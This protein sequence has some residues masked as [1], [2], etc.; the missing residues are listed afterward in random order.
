MPVIREVHFFPDIVLIGEPD[1][2]RAKPNYYRPPPPPPAATEDEWGGD[3][4]YGGGFPVAH[5]LEHVVQ[6]RLAEAERTFS[7]AQQQADDLLSEA[8]QQAAEMTSR[9][10]DDL[11]AARQ[12][13]EQLRAAAEDQSQRIR[14]QAEAAGHLSGYDAGR[15]DG[16]VKV[17]AEM[18]EKIAHVT[19]L[20]VSAAVDRRELLHNAE[21]E[22]VRLATRIA[23]KVI[24]RELGVDPA[25][26]QRMAEVGLRHVASDGLVKLRVN[27]EDFSE[28]RDYWERSHGAVEGDRRYEVVSDPLISR[29]G[30][31]IETRAGTVDA[32]IETQLDEIAQALGV[33]DEA[34]PV[35][36]APADSAPAD[37]ASANSEPADRVPVD[38]A[39]A[40]G[41]PA[42]R[43]PADSGLAGGAPADS[44]PVDRASAGSLPTAELPGAG[45]EQGEIAE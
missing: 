17:E 8:R 26:V 45:P 11:E 15:A 25:I 10:A 19:R 34:A 27:P 6:S 7:D 42:D 28:L 23:R 4:A 31:M 33:E 5:P 21:A 43:A 18:G 40:D 22:V 12:E 29:G 36:S 20:A 30:V 9:A 13:A 35:D 38:G 2:L 32:R 37:S 1:P 24:Q 3:G 39:L 44:G 16:L 14:D 41:A